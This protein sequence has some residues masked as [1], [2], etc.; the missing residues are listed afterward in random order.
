[1]TL[2]KPTTSELMAMLPSW[3]MGPS[4]QEQLQ[5]SSAL[6]WQSKNVP[7]VWTPDKFKTQTEMLMENKCSARDMLA[8]LFYSVHWVD[9]P[10]AQQNKWD[11][12]TTLHFWATKKEYLN[13]WVRG[14]NGALSRSEVENL[15][16]GWEWHPLCRN[17]RFT[18]VMDDFSRAHEIRR[19]P[20]NII[21]CESDF[22]PLSLLGSIE[23]AHAG[24][25][26][27]FQYACALFLA[28]G[29]KRSN[30]YGT[31]YGIEFVSGMRNTLACVSLVK[32]APFFFNAH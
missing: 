11:L 30:N 6:E 7:W 9:T 8:W 12:D 17:H 26:H 1:M 24:Q 20:Q 16:S 2:I 18:D 14:T 22:T 10:Q 32:I 25:D 29:Q 3:P 21:G 5:G 4:A 19:N 31:N 27:D 28:R 13:A 23:L 15:C